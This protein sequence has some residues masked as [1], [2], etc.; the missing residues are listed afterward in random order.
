MFYVLLGVF[1]SLLNGKGII[2]HIRIA[3]SYV[4]TSRQFI[5]TLSREGNEGKNKTKQNPRL[6]RLLKFGTTYS[7]LFMK[8]YLYIAIHFDLLLFIKMLERHIY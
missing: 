2:K 4:Y 5:V 1:F 3:W 7:R 6:T 8:D